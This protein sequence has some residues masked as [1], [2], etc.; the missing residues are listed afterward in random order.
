MFIILLD[1]L[2]PLEIVNQYLSAHRAYL[3]EAYQNN[4]LIASGPKN[5]RNGGVLLSQLKNRAPL[6]AW[7]AKDPFQI[8]GIATY[9]IIEFNPVKHHP[10]FANFIG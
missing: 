6:E 5:P 3:D 10:A 9:T 1:Y 8:N 2:V 4:L 7:L